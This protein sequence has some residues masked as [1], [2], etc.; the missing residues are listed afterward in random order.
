MVIVLWPREYSLAGRSRRPNGSLASL[1][2]LTYPV[3]SPVSSMASVCVA[4]RRKTAAERRA[5]LRRSEGRCL[6]RMMR[7]L[8]ELDG[9]RGCQTSVLGASLLAAI[10]T[11]RAALPQDVFEHL[12]SMCSDPPSISNAGAVVLPGPVEMCDFSGLS[13]LQQ[14]LQKEGVAKL[15]ILK[16]KRTIEAAADDPVCVAEEEDAETYAAKDIPVRYI[17]RRFQVERVCW[18]DGAGNSS[19]TA[20]PGEVLVLQGFGFGRFSNRPCMRKPNGSYGHL[21]EQDVVVLMPD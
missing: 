9:H 1:G 16:V 7:A 10:Q 19:C 21:S 8:L 4:R 13:I 18:L 2:F 3:S 12:S 6:Q 17:G 20:C 14:R 5:Q 15:C 11:E